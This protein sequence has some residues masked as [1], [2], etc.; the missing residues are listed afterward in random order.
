MEADTSCYGIRIKC[1]M[2]NMLPYKTMGVI[3][4]PCPNLCS[5]ILVKGALP[6]K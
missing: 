1:F 6:T 4:Y 5:T 2:E 3:T